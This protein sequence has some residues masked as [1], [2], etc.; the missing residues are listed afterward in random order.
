MKCKG[1]LI[2]VLY[3]AAVLI[4]WSCK[5]ATE[6]S[7]SHKVSV[8]IVTDYEYPPFRTLGLFI[9]V[10]S[11]TKEPKSYQTICAYNSRGLLIDST[12]LHKHSDVFRH[13]IDRFFDLFIPGAKDGYHYGERMIRKYNENDQIIEEIGYV[14]SY[15]KYCKLFSHNKAG[16]ISSVISNGF[17]HTPCQLYFYKREDF[18][19]YDASGNI[20]KMIHNDSG[21]SPTIRTFTHD[22]ANHLVRATGDFWP[23]NA[24]YSYATKNDSLNRLIQKATFEN[25]NL[26]SDRF[27]EYDIK[28]NI[29]KETIHNARWDELR[30]IAYKDGL[31]YEELI[32]YSNKL[33]YRK[34]YAYEYWF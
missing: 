7:P 2:G 23:N 24:Q 3:C 15:Q 33:K 18:F 27:I 26:S 16:R 20:V 30:V 25:G 34:T 29:A 11:L 1:F 17:D 13:N 12:E 9:E 4:S 22:S 32:Y 28:G 5:P 6:Y 21:Y 14:N 19:Y 10:D 8:M 31:K